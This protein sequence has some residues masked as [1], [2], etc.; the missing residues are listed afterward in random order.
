LLVFA[1]GTSA[2]V[3]ALLMCPSNF[4]RVVSSVARKVCVQLLALGP[5]VA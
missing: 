3:L 1:I 2:L 5:F 4:T